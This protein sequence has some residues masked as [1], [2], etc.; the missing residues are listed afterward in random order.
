MQYGILNMGFEYGVGPS[1]R[2]PK[3]HNAHIDKLS[4]EKKI[5]G[6]ETE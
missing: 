3:R 5:H 4:I 2:M 1:H 6:Y